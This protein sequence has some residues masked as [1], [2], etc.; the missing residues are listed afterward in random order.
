[1]T[2]ARPFFRCRGILPLE[3]GQV[4]TGSERGQ[5]LIICY[6]RNPDRGA[7]RH[8]PAPWRQLVMR[9]P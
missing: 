4:R 5:A 9:D 8:D 2:G 7:S 6:C 1:M 3:Q